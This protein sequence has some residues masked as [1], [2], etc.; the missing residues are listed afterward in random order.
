MCQKKSR[1]KFSETEQM[2]RQS[3]KM[4]MG[5]TRNWGFVM[6]PES[7]PE[8]YIQILNDLHIKWALSPLHDK[9]INP[10]TNEPKKAHW[11]GV[12]VFESVKSYEQ[13]KAITDSLNATIPQKLNSL[14]GAV[15]Y[16]THKDNP[17][18]AQYLEKDIVSGGGFELE[19]ILKKTTTEKKAIVREIYGYI[20][21]NDVTEF[22][23]LVDYAFAN[24]EDWFDVLMNGY[25]LFFTSVIKSRRHSSKLQLKRN[26]KEIG[27]N[28]RV[29]EE[30]GEVI[31]SL[32]KLQKA[33]EGTTLGELKGLNILKGLFDSLE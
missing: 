28:Y 23:E 15:R 16:F 31:D 5:R 4:K 6:Y 32:E 7:A 33:V 2:V 12:L 25:T 18:K 10:S 26:Q 20:V 29:D 27:E 30:T 13:V 9:D 11:H 8:N 21:Q 14:V 22:H 17:E 3:D 1:E 19:E 24:K